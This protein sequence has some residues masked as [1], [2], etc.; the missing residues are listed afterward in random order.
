[1][2]RI[3]ING[4]G[5]IGR[6]AFKIAFERRDVEIVAI[7]DLADTKTLAHLLQYDSNYGIYSHRVTPFDRGIIVAGHRIPVF[8]ETHPAHLPWGA[9]GVDVAMECSGRFREPN[10]AR[11]HLSAGAQKVVISAPV[12]GDSSDVK[13]IVLGVNEETVVPD[14]QILSNASCTT[15]CVAPIM[16]I[17]DDAFGVSKAMMTTIHSYTSSQVLLDGPAADLRETRSAA[18]NIIPTSTGASQAAALAVPSLRGKFNGLSVRVPTPVVSLADITA[19]TRRRVTVEE[20]NHLFELAAAEPYYQG[21]LSVTRVPLVSSDLKG[22]SHSCVIDLSLTDV[23]EDNLV[24]VVA[25]YDNEWGYA[26]RLVELSADFGSTVARKLTIFVGADYDGRKAKSALIQYLQHTYRDVD[27][28]DVATAM[29]DSADLNEPTAVAEQVSR[30]PVYS[31]G[32]LLQG[33]EVHLASQVDRL[34]NIQ[35]VSST[36]LRVIKDSRQRQAANVLCLPTNR[37]S[38]SE[39]RNLTRTFLQTPSLPNQEQRG[40]Y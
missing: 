29:S 40:A 9:L 3:A 4:F 14:D 10:Q 36:D 7:N 1:M 2:V 5:R 19:V 35:V 32:I 28:V 6:A 18:E 20:L 25:W 31:Y 27:V 30:H 8:S 34:P 16:K 21:L 12:K 23:V 38:F 15:N 33:S 13:T 22:N 24:K 11:M 37:L 26:N 39:M 17:I